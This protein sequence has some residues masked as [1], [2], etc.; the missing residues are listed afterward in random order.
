MLKKFVA[1]T[2]NSPRKPGPV[3]DNEHPAKALPS[4]QSLFPQSNPL[5]NIST[6]RSAA[7][8]T[9]QKL[10]NAVQFYPKTKRTSEQNLP[11]LGKGV[12]SETQRFIIRGQSAGQ[13]GKAFDRK[14]TEFV[15]K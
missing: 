4:S 8:P 9:N 15:P 10:Q 7:Q 6:R 11:P 5:R 3:E 1:F 2:D 12:E 14:D 13:S